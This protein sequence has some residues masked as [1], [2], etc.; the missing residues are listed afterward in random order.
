MMIATEEIWRAT[1]HFLGWFYFLCWSFSFYPQAIKNFRRNS[2]VGLAVDFPFSN[3]LGFTAY[4]VSTAVFLYSPTIRSQY[5]FR[6]PISQVPSVRFNDF[7]FALHGAILSIITYSQFFPLIWG[8][9]VGRNQR[10]SW[11]FRGIV[12]GSIA[13]VFGVILIV[14]ILSKDGGNDPLGWAWIDVIYAVG[15]VKVLVTVVKYCPQVWVN[16]Q[17]K[18]TV[19]WSMGQI[20]LDFAGGITSILQMVVDSSLDADWSGITGNPVKFALGNVS[21]IFDIIFIVQHYI[22]YPSRTE[23]DLADEDDSEAGERE[24]LLNA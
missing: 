2:T 22:L 10:S 7:A 14:L 16:Y 5:A 13:G 23:K 15:F 8:F 24:P 6:H 1:S 9:Q 12:T 3:I 17:R 11:V 21:M 4:S 20:L 18:S 19:G